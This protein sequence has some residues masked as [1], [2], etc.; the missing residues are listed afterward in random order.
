[1]TTISSQKQKPNLLEDWAKSLI[2]FGGDDGIRTRDLCLAKA[3]LSQLSHI[4]LV[5]SY[6]VFIGRCQEMKP[7]ET[8][9][10]LSLGEVRGVMI[11][12]IV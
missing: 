11:P 12:G 4:P 2:F 1:M 3:A 9:D 5:R 10:L 6:T 8:P 7:A